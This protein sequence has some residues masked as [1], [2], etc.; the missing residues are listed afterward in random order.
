[1]WI[2]RSELEWRRREQDTALRET[3]RRAES[4]FAAIVEC[5]SV[6]LQDADVARFLSHHG[7]YNVPRA[8]S[9]R[10]A[11]NGRVEGV[12]ILEGAALAGVV[13]LILADVALVPRLARDYPKELAALHGARM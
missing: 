11:S 7:I 4:Q 13:R 9:C 1:M 12:V 5:L 2:T 6:L 10:V 3:A 8:R